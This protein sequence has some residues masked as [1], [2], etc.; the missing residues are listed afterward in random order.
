MLDQTI[1]GP[2]AWRGADLPENAGHFAVSPKAAAEM[3]MLAREL[4]ANPLPLEALRPED[5]E[6]PACQALSWASI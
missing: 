6:L 3:E 5:F 4:A 2:I 1:T